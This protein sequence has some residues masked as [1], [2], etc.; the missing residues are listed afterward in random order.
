MKKQIHFVLGNV[1]SLHQIQVY[2]GTKMSANADLIT[3]E[4]YVQQGK[5]IKNQFLIYGLKCKKYIYFWLFEGPWGYSDI[6]FCRSC[7]PA[8]LLSIS[9]YMWNKEQS[10][11]N[12]LVQIPNMKKQIW[13]YLGGGG[14]LVGPDI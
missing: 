5:T 3:V 6:W 8:I 12:F 13:S 4:T 1:G 2:R 14:V 10:E 7:S 11:K 9:M